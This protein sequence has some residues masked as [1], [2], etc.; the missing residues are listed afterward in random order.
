[1]LSWSLRDWL[2][3]VAVIGG[4]IGFGAL[5]VWI[6]DPPSRSSRRRFK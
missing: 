6:L 2:I 5:L 3:A 4:T 1:M